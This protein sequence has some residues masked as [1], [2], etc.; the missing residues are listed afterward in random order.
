MVGGHPTCAC[1]VDCPVNAGKFIGF[2][3]VGVNLLRTLFISVLHTLVIL[4][5]G[6]FFIE[7]QC[8]TYVVGIMHLC[9]VNVMNVVKILHT[10]QLQI[11]VFKTEIHGI[12]INLL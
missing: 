8:A 9:V 4:K 12:I 5:Y 2:V 7:M 6:I 10:M 1:P 11:A 3:F